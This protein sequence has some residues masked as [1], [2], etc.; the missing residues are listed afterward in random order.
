MET[1]WR[2]NPMERRPHGEVTLKSRQGNGSKRLWAQA[3]YI[4]QQLS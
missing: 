3:V 2:G 1:P 4:Y